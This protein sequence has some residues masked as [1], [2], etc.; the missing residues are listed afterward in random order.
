MMGLFRL[1]CSNGL[2]VSS[3]DLA[4]YAIRHAGF[5]T[6]DVLAASAKMVGQIPQLMA[7]VDNMRSKQLTEEQRRQ[8]AAQALNLR[9][10]DGKAPIKATDLLVARRTEDRGT[11]LWSTLNVVQES[12][13][14]GGI[15]GVS[16]GRTRRRYTTRAVNS[17]AGDIRLNRGLWELA[18]KIAA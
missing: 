12:L 11:D 2:T 9:W 14:Q 5:K 18:E 17:P 8:F 6:E 1:V 3:G 4:E 13:I 16:N 7:I 15:A 10:D